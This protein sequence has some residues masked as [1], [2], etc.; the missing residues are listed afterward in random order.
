MQD[1]E[2]VWADIMAAIDFFVHT[3][4][5]SSILFLA[6]DGVAPR[7]KMNQQ[8]VRRFRAAKDAQ[9]KKSSTDFEM[10]DTNSIS[11]GTEFMNELN[12]QLKF[13]IELK[14]STDPLY[15]NV[16]KNF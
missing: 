3:I 8:R 6:I 7:S 5:P 2:E 9:Q 15:Q 11:P 1:L 12:K 16:R 10:F 14:I 4:K 13:F